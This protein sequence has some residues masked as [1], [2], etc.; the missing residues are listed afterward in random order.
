MYMLHASNI[1]SAGNGVDLFHSSWW[2][3]WG[4]LA[5]WRG[6]LYIM[7]PSLSLFCCRSCNVI[8]MRWKWLFLDAV[9][10]VTSYSWIGHFHPCG[11]TYLYFKKQ[12]SHSWFYKVSVLKICQKL[13]LTLIQSH[14]KWFDSQCIPQ[15]CCCGI[16]FAVSLFGNFCI[17]STDT[18]MM[19]L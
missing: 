4:W 19:I 13:V 12:T 7:A 15:E 17:P 11:S 8:K 10:C 6:G 14:S 9:H 5:V 18:W 2:P 1:I 3:T 16:D